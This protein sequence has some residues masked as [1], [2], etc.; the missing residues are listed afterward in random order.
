M[1]S[2]P[3]GVPWSAA[4]IEW[5]GCRSLPQTQVR[6][7][8]TTAS[9][10]ASIVGSGSC[11]TRTSPA[12]YM[13]VART[14]LLPFCWFG[15]GTAMPPSGLGDL[16][17]EVLAGDLLGLRATADAGVQGVDRGELVAGEF[18]VEDV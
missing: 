8:R 17:A 5:Y 16:A 7:T 6:T 12:P 4:G 13:T 15:S 3:I 9:V 10:G 14:L 2:W 1:N 11:S 18:E